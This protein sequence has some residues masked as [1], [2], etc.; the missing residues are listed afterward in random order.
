[1]AELSRVFSVG[2]TLMLQR[3]QDINGKR[4]VLISADQAS[5]MKWSLLYQRSLI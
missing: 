5:L 2:I 4:A 1:M 3:V